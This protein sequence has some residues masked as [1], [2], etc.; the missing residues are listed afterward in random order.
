MHL[1]VEK[2]LGLQDDEIG[3]EIP[4]LPRKRPSGS[5]KGKID[6][7][8]YSVDELEYLRIQLVNKV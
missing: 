8:H 6:H 1:E 4:L 7:G 3:D 2:Q 5:Y